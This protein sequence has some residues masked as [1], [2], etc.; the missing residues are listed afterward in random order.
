MI[1]EATIQEAV[2]LLMKAARPEKIILFGSYAR[3][4][5]REDSDL[6]FLIVE[7]EVESRRKKMVRLRRVLSP[8]A[9]S[10]GRPRDNRAHLPG[11]GRRGRHCSLRGCT[12]G[13]GDV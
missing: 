12:G 4:D 10:C 1:P 9:Y 3:G 6:D 2:D 13:G 8:L 5:A 11:M 7:A